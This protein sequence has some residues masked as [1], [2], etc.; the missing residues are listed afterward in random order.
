LSVVDIIAVITGGQYLILRWTDAISIR[1]ETQ[2]DLQATWDEQASVQCL[3]LRYF[4]KDRMEAIQV[5]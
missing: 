3:R 1:K 4:A 5:T 2:E